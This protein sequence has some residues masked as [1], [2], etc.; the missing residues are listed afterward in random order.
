MSSGPRRQSRDGR[1]APDV[2]IKESATKQ[3]SSLGPASPGLL[4]TPGSTRPLHR[5]GL[6]ADAS[7][8]PSLFRLIL[9]SFL[10]GT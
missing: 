6:G 9:P 1:P 7:C 8:G 3:S 5:A 2:T 10:T 4:R